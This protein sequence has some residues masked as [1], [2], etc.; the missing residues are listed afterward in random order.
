MKDTNLY[1]QALKLAQSILAKLQQKPKMVKELQLVGV[2]L[3]DQGGLSKV[4]MIAR[5]LIKRNMVR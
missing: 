5:E 2:H 4:E 3:A 1:P